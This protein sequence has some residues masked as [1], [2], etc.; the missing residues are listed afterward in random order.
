MAFICRREVSQIERRRFLCI[1]DAFFS[2]D[3]CDYSEL[4]SHIFMV[5]LI[6][7]C[8]FAYQIVMYLVLLIYVC[9]LTD[10]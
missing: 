3:F 4:Y 7:R 10:E 9:D 1:S 2:G 5:Y 8:E 6:C